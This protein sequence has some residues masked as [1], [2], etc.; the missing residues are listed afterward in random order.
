MV[1][2]KDDSFASAPREETRSKRAE[3]ENETPFGESKCSWSGA[4]INDIPGCFSYLF[5]YD[6]KLIFSHTML[7]IIT[8]MIVFI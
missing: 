4:V 5:T 8:L 7:S 2:K 1:S 6:T 3:Q